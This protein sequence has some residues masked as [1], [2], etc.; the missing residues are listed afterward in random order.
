MTKFPC[1]YGLPS[2]GKRIKEW[3]IEV[4]SE[5]ETGLSF[6]KRT[7]GYQDCKMQESIKEISKGKNIGKKNETSSIQQA[8]NEAQS[9][10]KKQKENGYVE[11]VNHLSKMNVVLP[12]LAHDFKKREKDIK[13]PCIA[14]P[15]IDGVRLFTKVTENSVVCF[16]RTGKEM[17]NLE[18]IKKDILDLFPSKKGRKPFYIDGELF[19]FDFP[20]EEISG[21]FRKQETD[22]NI[23][24]LKYY[25]F[26]FY[27]Q[28]DPNATFEN[29]LKYMNSWDDNMFKRSLVLVPSIICKSKDCIISQHYVNVSD[30]FEGLIIRNTDGIYKPNYRSKDL[31]KYK[32][33][34]DDEFE[35]VGAQSG[36]GLEKDCAIFTC[37]NASGNEFQVRPRGSRILR[38]EYL[39]NIKNII[40]KQLTVR[41]Q[42]LSEAGIVRFGVGI[43]IRDYE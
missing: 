11:D 15:K 34:Q 40:G 32:E 10:W 31:Q 18:H 41:Y 17:Q 39:K 14:Q 21:M 22:P 13:Y 7:H 26:D 8:T 38:K 43:S 19:S 9:L 28:D 35:I 1:L 4:Y 16:S 33:F 30:G 12:M 20:F 29:R 24:K 37:K 6:I 25:I 27:S 42:N 36:E 3:K 5:N 2:N 23:Q